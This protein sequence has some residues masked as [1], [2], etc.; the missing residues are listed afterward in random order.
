MPVPTEMPRGLVLPVRLTGHTSWPFLILLPNARFLLVKFI[1][2]FFIFI[3]LILYTTSGRKASQFR[4][5]FPE[6][7]RCCGSFG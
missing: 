5:T 6:L 1:I 2:A 7:T 4:M 3:I